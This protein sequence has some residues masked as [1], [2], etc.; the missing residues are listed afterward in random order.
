MNRLRRII[1]KIINERKVANKF[2]IIVANK[3]SFV[4]KYIAH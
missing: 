4:K 1:L 2:S 3:E